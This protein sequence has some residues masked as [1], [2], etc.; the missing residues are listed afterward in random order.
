MTESLKVFTKISLWVAVVAFSC[1]CFLSWGNLVYA[2][3]NNAWMVLP[4]S[5]FCYAGEAMGLTALIM[6][7]FEKWAWK[8]N[9]INVVTGGMP[10]LLSVY[11]GN[12]VSD[13][14]YIKRNA[15][16]LVKQSFLRVSIV[17][18]TEES[19]SISVA[20]SIIHINGDPKLVYHYI[21]EPRSDLRSGSPM[22]YGTAVLNVREPDM[23]SGNYYT[24]RKTK[25]TMEF[26]KTN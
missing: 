26:S 12:I 9:F 13:Y 15:E 20:A 22:H 23:I 5:L 3:N 24:D 2:I 4:Y 14:D 1:R 18:K 11:S 7:V 10:V 25:G 8:W 17:M 16:L 21:N 6:A 19:S